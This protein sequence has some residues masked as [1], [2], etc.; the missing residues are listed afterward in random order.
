MNEYDKQAEDFLKETGT[1]FKV[2]FLKSGLHFEGDEEPRDVYKIT[3]T[4]GMRSFSF[5]FGQ[6]IAESGLRLFLD[7]AK[8]KRTGHKNFIVPQEVRD[9][10]EEFNKK[11]HE[12]KFSTFGNFG[13]IRKW[14]ENEHFILSGLT[15]DMGKVPNP[16]DVLACLT[17]SE[18]GSFKD[19]C[20]NYGYDEDSRQAERTYKKVL[21]EWKNVKMLYSDEEI[22][23]LQEI[24]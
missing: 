7:K 23:K 21:E 14:F 19:F 20:D 9:K 3:L 6:S 13:F 8:T 11:N 16:Y 4:K 18:V 15:F 10:Q 12:R 17:S 5:D 1:K 24:Q 2:N 22:E